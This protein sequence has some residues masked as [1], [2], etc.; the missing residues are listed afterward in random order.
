VPAKTSLR[1]TAKITLKKMAYSRSN[2]IIS[3]LFLAIPVYVL[4]K[5]S[6][7]SAMDF[8]LLLFPYFFLV[9]AQ[10]MFRDEIESGNLENVIFIA[11]G[12]R[13]YLIKK[14][15]IVILVGTLLS[16]FTLVILTIAS[17]LSH[18]IDIADYAGFGCGL[19]VGAYYVGLA[20]LLSFFVKGGSNVLSIFLCQAGL[21]VSLI[22]SAGTGQDFV[23]ALSSGFLPD[24]LT[25]LKF[26]GLTVLFPNVVVSKKF[27]LWTIEPAFLGVLFLFLQSKLI[28][29][30]ELKCK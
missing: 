28:A 8:F 20:G 1:V 30:L 16:L 3:G 18:S 13:S 9:F 26:A 12:F 4:I 2:F 25:Q 24:I 17:L 7:K 22:V 19:I 14:N 10:N 21:A 5:D 29:R 6:S 11:G 23:K 15:L 27:W